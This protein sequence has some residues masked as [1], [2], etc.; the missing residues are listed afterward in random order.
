MTR[1]NAIVPKRKARARKRN[2]PAIQRNSM[3]TFRGVM[4]NPSNPG[5]AVVRGT[6]E[7]FNGSKVLFFQY[8]DFNSWCGP[9]RGVL[10]PFAF[11]R[12]VAAEV[13]IRIAGGAGSAYTAVFNISNN[14]GGDGDAVAILN[15]EY[16][17]MANGTLMPTIK[18]PLDY[19]KIGGRTWYN[20]VDPV[21]GV[22]SFPDTVA[23]E[24]SIFG[25]GGPTTT[26]ATPIGWA[27]VDMMLEFHT[28]V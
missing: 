1:N 15:D 6:V 12:V 16:S 28:L 25:A 20:A 26:P 18:T 22:P 5:R 14:Y 27:V 19:W 11:F 10:T 13:T 3:S 8:N 2:A 9:A 21:A 7:I 23:G 24:V 17:A 4:Y